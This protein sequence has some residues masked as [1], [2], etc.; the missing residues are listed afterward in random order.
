[1]SREFIDTVVLPPLHAGGH[2]LLFFCDL[3]RRNALEE[4][5]AT[6]DAWLDLDAAAK[7][8]PLRFA[9]EDEAYEHASTRMKASLLALQQ[10]HVRTLTLARLREEFFNRFSYPDLVRALEENFNADFNEQQ[11]S[12]QR[13][14]H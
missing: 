11:P 2:E 10:P 12:P 7:E 8:Q 4:V 1:M 14:V 6:C 5:V 3:T 9:D 13:T